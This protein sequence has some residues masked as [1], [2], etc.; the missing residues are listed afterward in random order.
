MGGMLDITTSIHAKS[1]GRQIVEP[2]GAVLYCL[3]K[4]VSL[5]RITLSSDGNGSIPDFDAQG[6]LR[7][8]RVGD[9]G[10]LHETL[11][12]VVEG[13]T[14]LSDALRLVT[15]NPAASLKLS[16]AK[17]R[18]AE[19]SDADVVVLDRDFAIARVFARGRCVAAEGRAIAKSTFEQ[20][21]A[22]G[23]RPSRRDQGTATI[24]GGRGA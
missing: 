10:S 24:R 7:G 19:G 5:E 4:G 12:A 20:P 8:L 21:D 22:G 23:Q 3:G 17:G 9:I 6:R 1:D 11:R 18:L 13:G 14:P 2:A 15:A 16:P